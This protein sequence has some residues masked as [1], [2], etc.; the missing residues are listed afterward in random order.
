MSGYNRFAVVLCI[1][2]AAVAGCSSDNEHFCTRYQYLYQQL[3]DATLPPY[4]QLRAALHNEIQSEGG[5]DKRSEMMLL[6]LD[7]YYYEVVP[8][9]ESPKEYCMRVKRW[10]QSNSH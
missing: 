10:Q 4:A 7:D 3:G 6:A 5:S 1:S 8:Y 2:L 9:G